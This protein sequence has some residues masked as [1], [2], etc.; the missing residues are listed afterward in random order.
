MP[1]PTPSTHFA[2]QASRSSVSE[3]GTQNPASTQRQF[4]PR[5]KQ[6]LRAIAVQFFVNGALFA[7]FIP[8][9]PEIRDRVGITV[10]GIGLLMSI[11]GISGL[12]ASATVGS[13][14]RRFGTRGVMLVAGAIV[15]L[16]LPI[17]GF[18]TTPAVLLLGLAGML[19]FD[20]PVDVAMNMQG[21][22]LSAR[23]HAPVMNRLHGLWSLGTVIG[24]VSSSRIAAAGVSLSTHLL[25]AGAVLL[26]VLGYVSRGLLID[27][28]QHAD[29]PAI[30]ATRNAELN[31]RFNPVLLLFVFAGFFAVA[32]ESTSVDWAAFRLADDFAV[33]AGLAAL[34]YVA[35]TAGMT[36][37][38]FSGDWATERIGSQRLTQLGIALAGIGLATASL[39]PNRY[40]V[41][42]GFAISGLGNSTLLPMLYDTAA[43]YPGR[44]GAGLGALTAGLR[45]ASLSI[46]LIVGT[47]AATNLSVGSAIA[48]VTLPAAV[49]FLVVTTLLNRIHKPLRLT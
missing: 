27:D 25:L 23:R 1:K 32:L 47:L 15:S 34:A 8:R 39:A 41:L 18:A 16:S 13:A 40:V 14:I 5:D 48:I 26:A 4:T 20:V 2:K 7:S 30:P 49:G 22:W 43:K 11:A 45:T 36:V 42:A 12:I 17:V 31:R 46:P 28:E 9:L 35:V 6:A 24:G 38:R 37:G 10:S 19:S 33:S 29:T 44:V 3:S 21:S